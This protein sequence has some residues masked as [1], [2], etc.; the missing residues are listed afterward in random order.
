MDI[1][2]SLLAGAVQCLFSTDPATTVRRTVALGKS[3]RDGDRLV[4]CD[5][6]VGRTVATMIDGLVESLAQAALAVWPEWLGQSDAFAE[7]DEDSLQPLM[8]RLASIREARRQSSV[9]KS[10]LM[11]AAAMA[12]A[13]RP[14]VLPGFSASVQLQQLSSVIA[15]HELVLVVHAASACDPNSSGL[16]GLARSLEWLARHV[17]ARIVAVLPVDWAGRPELEGITWKSRTV[18]EPE[19]APSR[20]QMETSLDEPPVMV[21]PIRGRPHPNSPGEQLMAARLRLD[22]LLGPLFQY[23]MPVETVRGSRYLVDL[24]WPEGKI[25]VEIDGYRAHSSRF[26]FAN[27]RH[28]DY[29]LQLSGYL[30]L[31]LTHE[32]VM[33]DVEIE[34][35][36]IRDM[37]KFRMGQSLLPEPSV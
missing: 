27:D 37:V 14:P 28:R 29:E 33:R 15:D 8:D 4:V 2:E 32:N 19:A 13:N 25:V 24:V 7:C 20:G 31:R 1:F 21:C 30:V 22:P 16:L 11:R 3:G 34:V 23:N 35:D 12:R 5:V 10:W 18:E 9:L 26:D 36:K 6:D 17:P